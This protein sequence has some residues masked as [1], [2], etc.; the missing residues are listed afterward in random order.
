MMITT[1]EED[2]LALDLALDDSNFMSDEEFDKVDKEINLD[3]RVPDSISED[4]LKDIDVQLRRLVVPDP[5]L[6][7][8]TFDSIEEYEA[9]RDENADRLDGYIRLGIVRNSKF[10]VLSI[11]ASYREKE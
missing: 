7:H 9:W 6:K 5:T 11:T 2:D 8:K 10:D 4:E 3:V 1:N